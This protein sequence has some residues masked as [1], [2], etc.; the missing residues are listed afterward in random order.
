M[1]AVTSDLP[2]PP[3]DR[4]RIAVLGAGSI[5][6]HLGGLL[7]EVAEVTLIGRPAAMEAVR[8]DGLTLTGGGRPTI[9]VPAG[10]LRAETDP[11]AAGGAD[12]VLVTVKSAATAEA[13]ASVAPHLGPATPLVSFQNGLHNP[14]A[15]RE[16]VGPEHP[17]VAGM[18]PYNVLQK[19]PG[20]F[21]QG[22]G[23]ALMI[24][25]QPAGAA[26]AEAARAAGLAVERR[27][28]MREV[29][30][31]KLLMNLNNAVNALSGLPLREELGQRAYRRCLALC[32]REALAAMRADGVRPARL[33]ALPTALMPRL[34]ALPDGVFRRLA[35]AAL[36]VDAEARSST[37][38]D[39]QR[40]RRTEIDSLQGE[41]VAMAARHGLAAPANTRLIEL[42][43]QAEAAGPGGGRSWSGPELLA[44]LQAAPPARM[45]Q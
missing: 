38:E 11:A 2:A 27:A 34:L 32:Q 25:D 45:P 5:G 15:I 7:A 42:V 33:G 1:T 35:A 37:W 13:A 4:L 18:V 6:C 17:V 16:A 39:L 20:V 40:G 9:R 43:R 31:G 21:H 29:Q 30:Y 23:G 24:D 44:R 14:A 22:S 28:D 12:L 26:L 19:A 10:G 36:Q 41:V 8:A 3:S